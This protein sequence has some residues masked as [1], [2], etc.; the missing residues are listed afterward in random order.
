MGNSS[1]APCMDSPGIAGA[2]AGRSWGVTRRNC[3][4]PR[5]RSGHGSAP[6]RATEASGGS[7]RRCREGARGAQAR[8]DDRPVARA[9]IFLACLC[10]ALRCV[11]ATGLWRGCKIGKVLKARH[12][13][14]KHL[15]IPEVFPPVAASFARIVRHTRRCHA[16]L[17]LA[18]PSPSHTPA[19]HFA[20]PSAASRPPNSA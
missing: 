6:R 9:T 17:S 16:L 11:L 13:R 2:T 4:A 20:H 5:G 7:L 18:P 10:A 12:D 1:T 19:R 3:P 8:G 15:C 14:G